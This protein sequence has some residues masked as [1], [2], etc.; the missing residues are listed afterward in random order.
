MKFDKRRRTFNNLAVFKNY[1]HGN[2]SCSL[3]TPTKSQQRDIVVPI[4]YTKF[5]A[6]SLDRIHPDVRKY[7]RTILS[8]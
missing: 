1:F 2:V 4:Y 6:V 7:F 3:I 5:A 8:E